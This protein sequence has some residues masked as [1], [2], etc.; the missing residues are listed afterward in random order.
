MKH[1]KKF[2]ESTT[3]VSL[4]TK[5]S[6][7]IESGNISIEVTREYIKVK[8]KEGFSIPELDSLGI[9]KEKG[10][11][12]VIRPLK[13]NFG[14]VISF[15]VPTLGEMLTKTPEEIKMKLQSIYDEKYNQHYIETIKIRELF[16]EYLRGY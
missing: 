11:Y 14:D 12:W 5:Y 4:T 7:D 13:T 1:L 2:N 6:S 10:V 15:D 3:P 16:V 8:V 9:K